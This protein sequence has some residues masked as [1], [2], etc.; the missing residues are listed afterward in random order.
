[1][2]LKRSTK[3]YF[4][5][6]I[7]KK[8]QEQLNNIINEY[9]R[10]V[11]L[12]IGRFQKEIPRMTEFDLLKKEY[13]HSFDTWLSARMI[14]NAFSEGYGMV[15]SAKSNAKT[16]GQ[17]YI[18]PYHYGKKIT[19]SETIATIEQNPKTKEFDLLVILGSIGNK[20][21]IHLPL[22]KHK[23]YNN[24]KDWKLSKSI[25]LTKDY[26]MFT[27]ETEITKKDINSE[28]QV[29]MDFGINKFIATSDKETIGEGYK[30]LLIKLKRKQQHSKAWYRCKEEIKEFINYNIKN[31][32]YNLYSLIVVEKLYNIHKNMKLKK[33]L[34]KNI[35]FFVSKWTVNYAYDRLIANCNA[36]RVP[37]RTVSNFRNSQTCPECNYA[38]KKNRKSQE[39]FCCQKC[40]YSDNADFTSAKVALLRFTS[41]N[42]MVSVAE[43]INLNNPM[44]RFV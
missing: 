10:I 26:V 4:R 44:Y 7:T 12:F 27:F 3:C 19:I 42:P 15:K 36:N 33:R 23:H 9:S 28:H 30:E 11:N 1:M 38:D 39:D 24:F 37:Y 17:N 16:R 14:K 18:R 34:S 6:F 35:R 13:I 25:T 41:Q 8:K 40:G 20:I 29:G 43:Q 31:L 5:K 32:N 22:K 21:K 2:K